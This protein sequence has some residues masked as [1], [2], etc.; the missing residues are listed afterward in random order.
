MTWIEVPSALPGIYEHC[1]YTINSG[2]PTNIKVQ[3]I[4][5]GSLCDDAQT[6][7]DLLVGLRLALLEVCVV[8]HKVLELV[9][10]ME[11]V[12]VWVWLLGGSERVDLVGADLKV[13]L[14][15]ISHIPIYAGFS[16]VW[17]QLLDILLLAFLLGPCRQGGFLLLLLLVLLA[18]LGAPLQLALGDLLACHGIGVRGSAFGG[19]RL[20]WGCL[21]GH[22]SGIVLCCLVSCGRKG[23]NLSSWRG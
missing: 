21:I 20:S 1:H 8:A 14:S 15:R 9:I 13:L 16:Y 22:C 3:R 19:G 12:R 6:D 11:L 23:N 7:A 18:L 4:G 5:G 2:V 17:V 10:D